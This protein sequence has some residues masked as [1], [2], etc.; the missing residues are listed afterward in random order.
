M[1]LMIFDLTIFVCLLIFFFF[2]MLCRL[3]QLGC[4]LHAMDTSLSDC[5]HV[6]HLRRTDFPVLLEQPVGHRAHQRRAESVG[7]HSECQHTETNCARR[8]GCEFAAALP[9][10]V[11]DGHDLLIH[12]S[13]TEAQ[14]DAEGHP[15]CVPHA[16]VSVDA[17]DPAQGCEACTNL[18]CGAPAG[19]RENRHLERVGGHLQDAH[20]RLPTRGELR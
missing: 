12:P 9:A 16:A 19:A 3:L 20:Q 11:G 4:N 2:L 5:L 10:A 8:D 17:A 13:G 6:H 14:L 18:R 1:L 15:D 7:G